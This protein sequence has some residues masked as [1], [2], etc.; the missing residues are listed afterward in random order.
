MKKKTRKSMLFMALTLMTG[1]FA[2]PESAGTVKELRRK[3]EAFKDAG[4]ARDV[5]AMNAVL[6]KDFRLMAF[7]GAATEGM[8][9]D[10]AGYVGALTAGKIGGT[11]RAHKILSLEV[12][13]KHAAIRIQMTSKELKFDTYMQWVQTVDGWQLVNDLTLAVPQAK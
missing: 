13:G 12:R 8:A 11:K 10:K 1:V 6:H 5:A 7:I 2:A 3:I 4:D 9:M